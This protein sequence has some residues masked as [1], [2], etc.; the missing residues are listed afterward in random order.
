M[1]NIF[2]L[3]LFLFA[4][5]TFFMASSENLSWLYLGLGFIAAI[6]V[7][8]F[9]YRFKL[10]DKKSELLYL[11]FGFYRNFL[12]TY[13]TNFFSGLKLLIALATRREPF[14]PTIHIVN[15]GPKK[16]LNTALFATTINMTTGLF[17]LMI[18]EKE[19]FI[20]AA[21]KEYFERL[22]L[23]KLASDLV[24]VNDDNLI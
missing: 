12:L 1:L 24:N 14:K 7:A 2:N 20:H 17:C 18:R 21:E 6:S 22:D 11:S 5:W 19:I 9:S 8:I 4:L 16:G 3:F 15:Y 13:V 10:I 23:K